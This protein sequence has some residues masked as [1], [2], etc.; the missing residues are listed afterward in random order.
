MLNLMSGLTKSG[1]LNWLRNSDSRIINIGHRMIR[2]TCVSRAEL[3]RRA[4]RDGGGGLEWRGR[5]SF[6]RLG[7]G[8]R[9]DKKITLL[10]NGK[11]HRSDG[12][13]MVQV[14]GLVRV[15]SLQF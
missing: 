13:S 1:N 5:P 15:V 7:G 6:D 4:G 14:V 2:H 12:E 11:H 9:F 10:G 8:S 3:A